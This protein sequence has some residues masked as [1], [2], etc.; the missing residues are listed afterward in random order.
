MA[1]IK[2]LIV[3]NKYQQS[4]GEDQVFNHE[5]GLLKSNGEEVLTYTATNDEIQPTLRNKLSVGARAVWSYPE[6]KRFMEFLQANN[7]DV[8]HVHNFFPL[9]SPSIYYACHQLNIP[10]VQTLHNYRLICPAATFLR[11]GDICEK[12]LDGSVLN[13]VRYACYRDSAL[14]TIPVAAMIGINKALHTWDSKVNRYI[15]LT[16]FA[17]RKFVE[18]GLPEEKISVKPNFLAIAPDKGVPTERGNYLLYVGRLSKEKGVEVLLAA[19]KMLEEVTE[20]KLIIIGDGPEKAKLEL[21]YGQRNNV[22]FAGKLPSPETMEYIGGARF[23]VAPSICYEGMPLTILEAYSTG[24]PV[25]ASNI[26]S[27]KE[28]VKDGS[29]GFLFEKGNSDNLYAV[30]K[31][32][33]LYKEYGALVRNA[34]REF[35]DKYTAVHNYRQLINIYNE[36]IANIPLTK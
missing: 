35:K 11:N 7:P 10:V 26:G 28:M 5:S 8:V 20:A 29:T 30:I 6:Y 13:S 2:I 18:S 1:A 24:T 31:K 22:I 32:A 15:A 17:K 12:C 25:I 33:L 4:G 9:I 14:Q 34:N 3:H 21:E 36:A 23:L 27:L 16:E 19:W